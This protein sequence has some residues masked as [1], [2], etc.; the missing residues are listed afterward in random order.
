VCRIAQF[1]VFF[2]FARLHAS[3]S[4]EKPSSTIAFDLPD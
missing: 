1:L 2:A 4:V 3:T